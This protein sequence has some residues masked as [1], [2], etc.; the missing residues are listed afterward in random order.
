V[1]LEDGHPRVLTK[2]PKSVRREDLVR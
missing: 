2:A 1:V